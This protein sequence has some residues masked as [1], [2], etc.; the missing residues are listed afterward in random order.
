VTVA[1]GGYAYYGHVTRIKK[2]AIIHQSERTL[3]MDVWNSQKRKEFSL[4]GDFL[5]TFSGV[6]LQAEYTFT[7]LK[8][9]IPSAMFLD[10][11]LFNAGDVTGEITGEPVYFAPSS[12]GRGFYVLLAYELPLHQ[13]L[14]DFLITPFVFYE[15]NRF[16]DMQPQTNMIMMSAGLNLRPSAYLVIKATFDYI[17]P[18]TDKFGSDLMSVAAQMAVSF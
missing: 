14:G 18:E 4:S 12:V 1:L 6:R 11:Q 9:I 2:R 5:L 17:I 7:Y 16:R 13:W 15:L 3:E 10:D 8:Q